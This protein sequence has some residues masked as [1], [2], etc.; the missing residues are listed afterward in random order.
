[1]SERGGGANAESCT[2]SN[3]QNGMVL[4]RGMKCEPKLNSLPVNMRPKLCFYYVCVV[5]DGFLLLTNRSPSLKSFRSA[6]LQL[7]DDLIGDLSVGSAEEAEKD[8]QKIQELLSLPQN[9]GVA[10]DS[11]SQSQ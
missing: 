6:R 2:S 9:E 8:L 1:M 4:T 3:S 5:T 10:Q 7:T 11:D